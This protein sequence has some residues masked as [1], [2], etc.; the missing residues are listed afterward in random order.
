MTH[1][2]PEDPVRLLESSSEDDRHRAVLRLVHERHPDAQALL[3]AA[4]SRD[5]SPRVRYLARRALTYVEAGRD[6]LVLPAQPAGRPDEPWPGLAAIRAAGPKDRARAVELAV[7]TGD[8][9]AAGPLLEQLARE[10]DEALCSRILDYFARH[11]RPAD[12]VR[13]L[14]S[15]RAR[16]AAV[17]ERLAAALAAAGGMDAVPYII[18]LLQDADRDVRHAA[19]HALSV[20]PRRTLVAILDA[21]TRSAEP[22]RR[23][24]A[25]HAL[26]R[27]RGPEICP[28][29]ASC[30]AD[31][32]ETVRRKAR[33]GLARIASEGDAGA[34][35]ALAGVDSSGSGSGS[36]SAALARGATPDRAGRR[37]LDERESDGGDAARGDV[38]PDPL[39]VPL[40]LDDEN[41]RVVGQ[42][43]RQRL[44]VRPRAQLPEREHHGRPHLGVGLLRQAR[45]DGVRRG[46]VGRIQTGLDR[47]EPRLGVE[48]AQ[49][50]RQ[51][52]RRGPCAV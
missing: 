14:P 43:S 7:R 3:S 24:S 26:A 22:W 6:S 13:L 40:G 21:M 48:F 31:A 18:Y 29:L 23:D 37:G 30:L 50:E 45:G 34:A 32:N 12:L 47:L 39:V 1:A 20:H 46:A 44:D 28:L 52:H 17:R 2:P 49:S 42:Q 51:V 16:G 27:M 41:P 36:G 35:A 38:E 11:G 4:A 33:D 8:R 10:R 25:V 9:R 15:L 19:R 5:S